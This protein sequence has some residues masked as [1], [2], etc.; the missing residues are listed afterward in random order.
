[1][2]I[3]KYDYKLITHLFRLVLNA[4]ACGVHGMFRDSVETFRLNIACFVNHCFI[5]IY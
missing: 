4:S 3:S 1:M 5:V 2:L